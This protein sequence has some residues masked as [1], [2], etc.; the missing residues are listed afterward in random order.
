MTGRSVRCRSLLA[1]SLGWLVVTTCGCSP[2]DHEGYVRMTAGMLA[3]RKVMTLGRG[4]VFEVRVYGQKDLSG[5]FRVGGRGDISF[6]LVGVIPVEGLS[7]TQVETII[8]QRLAA[9]YL[10]HPFV[11]VFVK[12]YNSKHISVIG[13]VPKPGT[14]AYQPG[15]NIIQAITLAGGLEESAKVNQVVVTRR[16]GGQ[17]LRYKIPVRSISEGEVPN[18]YLRPDDIIFVPKT[19]L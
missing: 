8:K 11:T 1:V 15:M 9:G 5:L 16:E 18:F 6:P 13:Q 4:D 12:E 10:K 3:P 19:I 2:P 7:P 14:F 17:E